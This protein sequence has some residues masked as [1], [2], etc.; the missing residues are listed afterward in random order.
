MNVLAICLNNGTVHLL[1]Y[2][3]SGRTHVHVTI[4]QQKSVS[5]ATTRLGDVLCLGLPKQ[6]DSNNTDVW[7]ALGSDDGAVKIYDVTCGEEIACLE[8]PQRLKGVVH[9]C[10]LSADHMTVLVAVSTGY[11]CRFEYQMHRNQTQATN[12]ERA[13]QT[14]L[15]S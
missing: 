8:V 13:P 11:I 1:K 2:D 9:A 7:A 5:W 10:A 6:E 4:D 14:T 12:L 3:D 15:S